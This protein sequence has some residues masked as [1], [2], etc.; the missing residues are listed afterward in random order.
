MS[1]M[2]STDASGFNQMITS[3]KMEATGMKM[4]TAGVVGKLGTMSRRRHGATVGE[5]RKQFGDIDVFEKI[6]ELM[7][8]VQECPL[9]LSCRVMLDVVPLSTP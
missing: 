2:I 5:V 6:E 9:L 3:T 8:A 7:P 1:I 4:R